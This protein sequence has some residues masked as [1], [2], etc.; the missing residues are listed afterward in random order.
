MKYSYT[1]VQKSAAKFY[2]D[3]VLLILVVF[4]HTNIFM[5]LKH[6]LNRLFYI[7]KKKIQT[8]YILQSMKFPKPIIKNDVK[9]VVY[10]GFLI[11]VVV[12]GKSLYYQIY[13]HLFLKTFKILL[14]RL[15][16]IFFKKIL[17]KK[18]TFIHEI[19]ITHNAKKCCQ[20]SC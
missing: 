18:F 5:F 13:V 17:Y 16:Y 9:F 19:S 10:E 15:F 3:E 4:V 14:C 11:L 20:D 8:K 1:I 12:S 6:L 7:F 2:Q